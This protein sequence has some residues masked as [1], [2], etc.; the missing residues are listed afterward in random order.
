[1]KPVAIRNIPRA[2]AQVI[3]RL[4][5]A[6]VSTAH[7]AQGRTGLA[8]PYLRPAWPGGSAFGSAVTVLARPGD[9]WMIH[10]AVELC[11]EGDVLVVGLSSDNA[12]GMFGELLAASLMARGVRGLI[13]D[14]GCRD[15]AALKKIGFP[16]WCRAVSAQGT[17]KASLGAVNVPVVVAGVLVDPGDVVI[18]DD[19]GVVFV[20]RQTANDTAEK[21]DARLAKESSVRARLAS[22]ELGLDVYGMRDALAEAG[23]VYL[24]DAS[25]LEAPN[26]KDS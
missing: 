25:G 3:A 19:D 15:V 9:N 7:E 13:I 12:D 24:D 11:R 21:C 23:L 20:P 26:R 5:A 4:G 6:G 1:M 8:K 18:A 14:A 22:G 17:V 10:V 2:D 16:V